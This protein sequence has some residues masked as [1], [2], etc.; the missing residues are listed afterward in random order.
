M[1]KK[2]KRLTL[3]FVVTAI[4][5]PALAG[6]T[7]ISGTSFTGSDF[8]ARLCP[9]QLTTEQC[10]SNPD[11]VTFTQGDTFP[12]HYRKIKY[13]NAYNLTELSGSQD[14]VKVGGHI[15]VVNRSDR[16]VASV[17]TIPGMWD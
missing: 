4:A 8:Q 6:A 14:Y 9:A 10:S 2:L 5:I 15:Y 16:K 13:H 17:I 1:T 12:S 11:A 3:G 7:A